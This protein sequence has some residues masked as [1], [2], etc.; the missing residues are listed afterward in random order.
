M[1]K[2]Y[3]EPIFDIEKFQFKQVLTGESRDDNIVTDPFGDDDD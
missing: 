1:K 2:I 3:E